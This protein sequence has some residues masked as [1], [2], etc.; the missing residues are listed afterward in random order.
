MGA[1]F[2]IRRKIEFL[3]IFI[4]VVFSFIAPT[5]YT[6]HWL[7]LTF[8]ASSVLV[9]GKSNWKIYINPLDLMFLGEN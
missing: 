1:L 3:A 2:N 9:I 5:P 4:L 6:K 8:C 7:F